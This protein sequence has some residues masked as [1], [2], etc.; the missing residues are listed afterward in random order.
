MADV[1]NVHVLLEELNTTFNKF[2]AVA[3]IGELLI[4]AF[5]LGILSAVFQMAGKFVFGLVKIRG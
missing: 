4:V 5:F 1:D 2:L 3:N